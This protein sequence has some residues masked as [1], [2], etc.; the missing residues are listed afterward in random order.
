MRR[1]LQPRLILLLLMGVALLHLP[2]SSPAQGQFLAN[3]AA[4]P[5]P[6]PADNPQTDAKIRLGAQLYFDGRLSA[7]GTISCATCHAPETGWANHG[8]TD[9]GIGGQVGGRNSGTIIDAAYMRFQFWDGRAGSLEEQ[10]LGPIHNPIEMGETLENVVNKL[11]AIP[12][13]RAQFQQVFGTDVTTDGIGKAIAAFER[14]IISGPSP[15]DEYLAGNKKAMSAAAVRGLAIFNGKGHCTPCHS[16][17]M[18]SDQWFH[19]IGVG[20]DAEKPDLGREAI[21]NDPRDR[22][23]FKTPGLRN[24]ALTHPYL[25]NGAEKT[26]MDVVEYYNR[27]GIRNDNLDPMMLP[28]K[29]TQREKDDLVAFLEALT[30]KVP[31]MKAPALPPDAEAS[32]IPKGGM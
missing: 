28:L 9:T 3:T 24:I 21:T 6:V 15:Y 13:Y 11:N 17:P 2:A 1:L 32:D 20:M 8:A 25:H 23:K 4:P 26:L 19:N 30:G 22:G 27:G 18:F 14:T 10:A 29:L 5:V 7:D 12:G 16:G 31:V